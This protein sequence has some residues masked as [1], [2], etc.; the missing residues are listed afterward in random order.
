VDLT[1]QP[2]LTGDAVFHAQQAAEKS[3]KALLTWHGQVFRKT[4]DLTELGEAC[5]RLDPGIDPLL[6]RA[7]VLTDYSWRFRYPGDLDEPPLHEAEDALLV[8][9][10]VYEAVL[11]R[12]PEETR[13]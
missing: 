10:E 8:A 4:H 12:L 11:A 9:R 3:M 7:A 1:A 6:R 5:A 13:P 2:P